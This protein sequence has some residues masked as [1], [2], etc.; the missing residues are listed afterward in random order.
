MGVTAPTQTPSARSRPSP[1][2]PNTPADV[3]RQI[4]PETTKWWRIDSTPDQLRALA[5]VTLLAIVAAG[6][7]TWIFAD[8]LADDTERV[9][10]STGEVLVVNQQVEASFAEAHAAAVSVHLAGPAGDRE[11]RR[12]YESAI[13]RAASGLEQVAAV[14]GDDP[15]SHQDLSQVS[16]L[17]TRY[18]GFVESARAQALAGDPAGDGVLDQATDITR[19]QISPRLALVTQRFQRELTEQTSG[20]SFAI[21]FVVFAV[22]AVLLALG[23]F[24]LFGRFRRIINPPLVLATAVVVGWLLYSGWAFFSQQ[25]AM[26]TAND[27]AYAS[28]AVSA[29]I[30]DLAFEHRAQENTR[31][32]AGD[33]DAGTQVAIEALTRADGLFDQAAALADSD[34]ERAAVEA[35]R[36]RWNRYL[37]LSFDVTTALRSGDDALAEQI[38]SGPANDAFNGF[39]AAAEALLLDNREQFF[40][41]VDYAVE[42]VR[43]LR[44]LVIAA[45]VAAAVLAWWGYSIRLQEYR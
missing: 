34:R 9:A 43:W 14:V 16:A 29:Q 44:L 36:T 27:D 21:G 41:E 22:V 15:A 42:T 40:A 18:V 8:R 37:P 39:N 23:Q 7:A 4:D 19:E 26:N 32:L 2:P 11:Q 5:V 38:T 12:L 17:T 31:V 25:S 3:A 45:T 20:S 35:V 28:I 33:P 6:I 10:N 1:A 13:E 30:Q 24:W